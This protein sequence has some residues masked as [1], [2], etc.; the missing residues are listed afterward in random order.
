M[1]Q[2]VFVHIELTGLTHLVGRLWVRERNGVESANFEYDHKWLNNPER[3]ALEP[4]SQL[5]KG[6]F[7]TGAGKALFAALGD[8][9]PDR[10]GRQLMQRA[11]RMNAIEQGLTPR[12]LLEVDYL[13]GVSDISRQGSLRFSIDENGPFLNNSPGNSTPSVVRLTELLAA[14]D[15]V[16]DN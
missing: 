1:H 3:F 12:Q 5:G 8:S 7:H 6:G 14:A 10:W 16:N 11:P 2:T 4:S 15:Q 13:L 9:A